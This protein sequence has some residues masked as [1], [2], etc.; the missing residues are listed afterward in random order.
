MVNIQPN[1]LLHYPL[2]RVIRRGVYLHLPTR[3]GCDMNSQA[4]IA[5]SSVEAASVECSLKRKKKKGDCPERRVMGEDEVGQD[6]K[7]PL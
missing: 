5:F 6:A 2:E 3:S 4:T 7:R 1:T